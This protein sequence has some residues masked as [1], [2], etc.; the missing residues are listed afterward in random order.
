M[1]QRWFDANGATAGFGTLTG[2]WNAAL[3]T[4]NSAGTSATSTYTF[5][6]ADEALFGQA[7]VTGTA[8]TVTIPT[9]VAVTLNKITT[10]NLAAA[11]TI[12][13]AGT[14]SLTFAGTTP[15]ISVGSAGGLILQAPLNGTVGFTKD[16]ANELVINTVSSG[17]SGTVT[18]SAGILR[19]GT[20]N[21]PGVNTNIFPT[22]S[23][24]G[25]WVINGVWQMYHGNNAGYTIT[26]PITGSGIIQIANNT[27]ATVSNGITFNNLSG[28]TGILLIF[29]NGA[30]D[31]NRAFGIVNQFPTAGGNFLF[32][33]QAG[34]NTNDT[35]TT[36][37]I[38]AA[39][40]GQ[41]TPATLWTRITANIA[42]TNWLIATYAN[43]TTGAMDFQG[44]IKREDTAGG[45]TNTPTLTFTLGG[46]STALNT[47]SGQ[48]RS[49]TQ[50]LAIS[51]VDAGTWVFSNNTNSYAAGTTVSGGTLRGTVAA[52]F[53]TGSVTMSGTP[54]VELIGGNSYANVINAVGTIRNV[55]GS[56]TLT[57]GITLAG[58]T[59][60]ESQA[61]TLTVSAGAVSGGGAVGL[62]L[63]GAGDHV[64]SSTVS[65]IN[66]L[67]K[68]GAGTSLL[69]GTA[70][71]FVGNPT[72]NAG[73]L[74]A[75]ALANSG[76]NSSI[77]AGS[78]IPFGTSST[79]F[80][81]YTGTSVATTN[82]GLSF[83]GSTAAGLDSSA[84][85]EF[86]STTF[87][88]AIST[89]GSNT[90]ALKGSNTGYNTLSAALTG[91]HG[92]T[93]SEA[94]RWILKGANDLTGTTT[95]SAGRLVASNNSYNN[96]LLGGSVTVQAG[97]EIQL[98]AEGDQKGRCA[99]TNLTV[100]GTS[101]NRAKIRIGGT[102]TSPTV[103]LNGNLAL[104]TGSA[105]TNWDLTGDT[106]KTPG[107]Y[108]LFAFSGAFGVTGGTVASNVLATYPAGRSGV[109]SYNVGSPNTITVTI[110]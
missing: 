3:W 98:G 92:F 62:T 63:S 40:T 30:A 93:K 53:G 18:L 44:G 97:G 102:A 43:Q 60:L 89:T 103:Y 21:T 54:T 65:G 32:D 31:N 28:F 58:T 99:Y 67:T 1:A 14:G 70:N 100:G 8:G 90:I 5:T 49:T 39:A 84:T 78:S 37:T 88:G 22:V 95:V 42:A 94:G 61:G 47:I 85:N 76:S 80:L 106:F 86:N 59:T 13:Y 72:I 75:K 48:I 15:T 38:P 34:A 83:T 55:S 96:K 56:N 105:K 46:T 101:G 109:L 33:N 41:T 64:I 4:A 45:F 77:G 69:S 81:K 23:S 104:P 25:A 12:T 110:S 20:V 71:Y 66:L 17:L 73:V 24:S 27:S 7:A 26:A 50:G 16:G 2:N 19:S 107:T 87:S 29:Q 57:G 35:T 11:Q 6:S 52:A 68:N 82:R 91:A 108:T 36:L 10:A 9:G 51:K 79:G 74:E